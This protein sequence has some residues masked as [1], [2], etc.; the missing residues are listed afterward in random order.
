VLRLTGAG[1]RVL[2]A[3]YD[4]SRALRVYSID[5][6]WIRHPNKS[7]EHEQK[8]QLNPNCD[9]MPMT[10][11]YMVAPSS[12]NSTEVGH[13]HQSPYAL[14]RLEFIPVIPDP[15]NR[16]LNYPSVLAVFSIIVNSPVLMHGAGQYH[17]SVA[18]RWNLKQGPEFKPLPIIE[19]MAAKAKVALPTR[20]SPE[21]STG[22]A[23]KTSMTGYWKDRQM[24][25]LMP[26]FSHYLCYVTKRCYALASAT[27]P[28]SSDLE[29]PWSWPLQ[30]VKTRKLRVFHRP[31]SL[32][33]ST[34]LKELV[35]QSCW[36]Q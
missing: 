8:P 5:F 23:N 27:A 7:Q 17:V 4:N 12:Q 29:N 13:M 36:R 11:Q 30:T 28:S 34:R 19:E 32:S 15:S 16:D 22:L 24:Y 25:H 26:T 20:V 21:D 31:A 18:C 2:L 10:V 1:Q 6:G 9:V 3:T 35:W 14:T 33:P